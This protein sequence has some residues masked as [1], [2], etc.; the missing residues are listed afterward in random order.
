M[1]KVKKQAIRSGH[2]KFVCLYR[3]VLGSEAHRSLGLAARC[4]L[5]EFYDLYNGSNNGYIFMSVRSAAERLGVSKNT[6]HKALRELEDRG[7]VRPHQ[8]SSFDW[9]KRL[10]T[11]WIL[12]E[13]E[14]AGQPA[15]K[16]FMRWKPPGKI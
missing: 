10:A 4:L 13:Y 1:G 5:V 2:N 12:A 9:K 8:R 14:Y 6:A 11:T 7:F 16:E 3:Y 15:S